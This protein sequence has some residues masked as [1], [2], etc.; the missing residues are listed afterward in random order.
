MTLC[1]AWRQQHAI[2]LASDSRL[3]IA[4]NSYADVG[5]KVLPLPYRI[6]EPGTGDNSLSRQVAFQGELGLCFAGSAVNSLMIKESVATLL[7]DLQYAP[8]Y[9]D[10]SLKSISAFIFSAYKLISKQI[11]ETAIGS[12]G[13][14]DFIIC[15]QCPSTSTLRAFKFSTDI[16]NTHSLS[17]VLVTSKHEFLGS[18]SAHVDTKTELVRNVEY[19]S[20]LRD[21]INDSSV[22][23]VGGNIQ[24]GTL[25]LNQFKTYG[26]VELGSGVH[27]WRGSLDTNS[28]AFMS[29]HDALIPGITCIDPFDAFGS[30]GAA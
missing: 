2:H 8:G 26:I 25:H 21:V 16:N 23:S 20:L 18:G 3:T 22:P 11:C 28:D 14:A 7:L 13:V 17:E 6:L 15:G 30:Q 10:V 4:E 19:L 9:T 29:G 24:Y 1:I 5:I 27:H 12:K